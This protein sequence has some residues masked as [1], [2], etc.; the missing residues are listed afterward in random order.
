M[1]PPRDRAAAKLSAA[2]HWDEI[3]SLVFGARD[4]VAARDRL[5]AAPFG[6]TDADAEAVLATTL[7]E[8][9]QA[10][11]S[12]LEATAI[13]TPEPDG[14]RSE[15]LAIGRSFSDREFPLEDREPWRRWII[16]G[17][18]HQWLTVARLTS[19]P[20]SALLSRTNNDRSIYIDHDHHGIR[21]R[22][23]TAIGGSYSIDDDSHLA[24]ELGEVVA[25]G[26]DGSIVVDA[27]RDGEF[28]TCQVLFENTPLTGRLLTSRGWWTAAVSLD[29]ETNVY[30]T[31]PASPPTLKLTRV[32]DLTTIP[33][34][35]T[36]PSRGANQ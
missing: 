16:E 9:N 25:P 3:S 12:R 32:H 10:N 26:G 15:W 11:R 29:P 30:I 8:I 18:T 36:K 22:V 31:G 27:M 17:V 19:E 24:T 21:I 1:E 23:H 28:T 5:V 34:T 6:F 14:E 33:A 35:D 13:A 4:H 7:T 20:T 2:R